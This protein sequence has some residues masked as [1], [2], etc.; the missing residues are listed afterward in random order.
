MVLSTY[1]AHHLLVL[2]PLLLD[3]RELVEVM[4]ELISVSSKP[5]WVVSET[6]YHVRKPA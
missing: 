1:H 5:N 2:Q 3:I 6:T 4:G